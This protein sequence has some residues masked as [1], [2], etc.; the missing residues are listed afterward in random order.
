MFRSM[1]RV[2]WLSWV[3]WTTTAL[4][5]S[6][7]SSSPAQACKCMFPPVEAAREDAT[8]VF[9][10][11]V[12]SIEDVA[13]GNE[14]SLGEKAITLAVVRSWKGLERDER[15]VLYTNAQSAACGYSFAKDTSYLVYARSAEDQKLHVSSCS[16]T[17]PLADAGEDLTFLG[18]GS[19][20]VHV[21]NKA[22]TPA[23]PTDGTA[24]PSATTPTAVSTQPAVPAAQP[25]Q[26]KGCSVSEGRDPGAASAS[27]WL[28]AL[29]LLVLVARRRG[30]RSRGLCARTA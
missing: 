14:P 3:L 29:P 23:T 17:K 22:A 6:A 9:E 27:A 15:I 26:K 8:A 12:L 2:S 30:T 20:P 19:T 25:A 11:R 28:L 24:A 1:S 21:E 4:A 18:A 10:G 5:A 13:T 7:A 16:R